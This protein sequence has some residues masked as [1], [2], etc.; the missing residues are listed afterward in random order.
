[1]NSVRLT[2]AV[3]TPVRNEAEN[4]RRLATALAAQ[5]VVPSAWVLVDTGSSDDTPAIVATLTAEHAWIR[6]A[7][8]EGAQDLARGGP[9]ARAFELGYSGLADKPDVIVKLDA[10][11]SFEP[12]Y[13]ERLLAEFEA[14]PK[15]GMA[16]GTCHE[17]EDGEW[18]ERHVTGSTVWGAS[19]CYRRQCL[20][21]VLP[22]E[23]RMGWDGVDEFRANA[24]G[25]KTHV[26]KD[27]PFHHH[28][29][30]GER[31][32]AK[33]L[34]RLAQG[35]A[36]RYIGY[37]FWYLALRALWNARK[38]PAALAMI[39]GYLQAALNREPQLADADARA[40]LRRQ[41]SLRL[42]P[43]RAAEAIGRRRRLAS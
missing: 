18:R 16:S 41:Q 42:L 26:F 24:R 33:H 15:L 28:R 30:E 1:M 7:T 43:S 22:L 23:Q 6:A 36:A 31:D 38:E 17:L 37:R 21:D 19:R 29:R 8:L 20:T 35:R 13:F 34:A 10:D 11:T 12:G 5:S 39:W 40:Y 25:W 9:I 2:Y 14:D 27:L 3:I 32:G 4:I